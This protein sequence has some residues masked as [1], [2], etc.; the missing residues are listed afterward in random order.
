[1]PGDPRASAILAA[2]DLHDLL[3]RQPY[4]WRP[5]RLATLT[6]KQPLCPAIHTPGTPRPL[7][8]ADLTTIDRRSAPLA[9]RAPWGWRTMRLPSLATND[10]GGRQTFHPAT[11]TPSEP[12]ARRPL[13]PATLKLTTFSVSESFVCRPCEAWGKIVRFARR[14]RRQGEETTKSF[15]LVSVV[16]KQRIFPQYGD[17]RRSPALAGERKEK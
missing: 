15:P 3:S 8:L 7:G 12:Y 6:P 16:R 5:A 14:S 11:L 10:P 2:D 9:P 1:M 4:I 13:R 17:D